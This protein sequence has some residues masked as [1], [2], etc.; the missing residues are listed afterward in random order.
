MKKLPYLIIL[1][2]L[3][4]L[5]LLAQIPPKI[6]S[7]ARNYYSDAQI[8]KMTENKIKKINFLYTQ[9]FIIPDEFKNSI[10]PKNIDIRQYSRERKKDSQ[11]KVFLINKNAVSERDAY[12]SQYIYLISI[13][14]LQKAYSEL[15]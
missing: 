13:D 4:N 1:V 2:I 6:D 9:S 11:A 3:G 12:L 7:R 15:K 5:S 14:D 10:N 8:S